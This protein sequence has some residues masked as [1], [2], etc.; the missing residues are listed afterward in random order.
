MLLLDTFADTNPPKNGKKKDAS[1]QSETLTDVSVDNK[2]NDMKILTSSFSIWAKSWLVFASFSCNF[3][4]KAS[5]ISSTLGSVAWIINSTV[6]VY[7]Q[8]VAHVSN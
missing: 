4:S 5:P 7:C 8:K 6:S 3:N 2:G 1:V